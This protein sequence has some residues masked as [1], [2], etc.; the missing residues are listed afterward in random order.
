MALIDVMAAQVIRNKKNEEYKILGKV[1]EGGPE[2]SQKEPVVKRPSFRDI[3]GAVT[4]FVQVGG[5]FI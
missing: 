4:K 2:N 3:F 5:D 1:D